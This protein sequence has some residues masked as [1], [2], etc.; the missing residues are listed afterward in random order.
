MNNASLWHCTI[1]FRRMRDIIPQIRKWF[2]SASA[3][4]YQELILCRE[5]SGDLNLQNITIL[6]LSNLLT[7]MKT[8]H[9]KVKLMRKTDEEL[10]EENNLWKKRLIPIIVPLPWN[11]L[12]ITP[13]GSIITLKPITNQCVCTICQEG[14]NTTSRISSLA[15][16]H[17][18]HEDCIQQWLASHCCLCPLCNYVV[19]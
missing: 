5:D 3:K 1:S 6:I 12:E 19:G 9:L 11:Y 13:F 17:F 7:T 16:T 15:C 18:Y 2:Q 14:Y 8:T 4:R 10:I